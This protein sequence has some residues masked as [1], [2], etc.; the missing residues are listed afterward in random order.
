[1]FE[2]DD[3]LLFPLHLSRFRYL[4]YRGLVSV[5]PE[6]NPRQAKEHLSAKGT[7]KAQR[8]LGAETDGPA[9]VAPGRS[10]DKIPNYTVNDL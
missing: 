1:M 9:L 6:K 4:N 8:C 10:S 7:S 2:L 3:I 5:L